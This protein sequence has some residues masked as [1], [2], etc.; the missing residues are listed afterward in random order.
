MPMTLRLDYA[1][2]GGNIFSYSP[3]DNQW[4]INGFNANKQNRQATD[5][6]ATVTIDFSNQQDLWEGFEKKYNNGEYSEWTFLKIIL[7]HSDGSSNERTQIYENSECDYI[8]NCISLFSF[9]LFGI[10]AQQLAGR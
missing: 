3:T 2:G 8:G 10:S 4:W 1:N 7:Q 5:V 9:R 6:V